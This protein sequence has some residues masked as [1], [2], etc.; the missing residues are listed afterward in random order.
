M[1]NIINALLISLISIGSI[2]N[3][4]A[5]PLNL[6]SAPLTTATTTTVFPNVM[7]VLDNSGSMAWDYLPDIIGSYTS[8][9]SLF[10]NPK[11]NG[12]MY[13]P[14][15]Y[16]E[17]PYYINSD[18]TQNTTTYPIQSGTSSA[19]GRN[20]SN[21][22]NPNWNKVKVDGF[23]VQSSSTVDVQTMAASGKVFKFVPGEICTSINLQ[24]CIAGTTPTASYPYAAS[25]RWCSSKANATAASPAA[26]SCRATYISGSFPY[27]RYPS[28]RTATITI[29]GSSTTVVSSIKVNGV[30]IL[31]APTSS[32]NNTTT[33]AQNIVANINACNGSVVGSCGAAGYGATNSGNVVTIYANTQA[34]LAAPAVTNSSGS[35][36]YA[37][38]AFSYKNNATTSTANSNVPGYNLM[39][40]I[41][42]A[43]TTALYPDVNSATKAGA[44][45]DCSGSMCTA[46]EELINYANWY[47]YYHTR[48]QMMKT[49]ASNAF[50]NIGST[51]RVGF[52]TINNTS[53]NT[54]TGI[55]L[56]VNTFDATQKLAWYNKFFAVS[57]TGSTTLRAAL[58][59]TGRY[60]AHKLGGS[61][62]DPMQYSCQQNFA[63][64]STDGYWNES[65]SSVVKV[66]GSAMTDQ[67]GTG[68]A[69]PK[70]EGSSSSTHSLADA[71]KYYYDTDL[72]SSSLSN[73]TGS[74]GVDVCTDN[75]F[76]NTTDTNSKQH[77]TDFTLGLGADGQLVYQD[78]YL[79]ASTGD[80]Y[81]IKQ[82]TQN[83]PLPASNTST[84]ID[85]LWH[86]AVNANGQYF[87]AKNPTD[88]SNGLINALSQINSR[89]GAG[90][91]AAAS[92]LNPVAGDNYAYVASYTTA[93]WYGNLEQRSIDTTT[94]IISNTVNWCVENVVADT[95]APPSTTVTT[96]TG[97]SSQTSCVT[98]G[99]SAATCVSPGV[100][101][102]TSNTCSVPMVNSCTGTLPPMVSANSDSR[103]IYMAS[104]TGLV[105]FNLSSFNP[106]ALSQYS[107]LST[108]QQANLTIA[109]LVNYLRG[110]KGYE[111]S[112]SNATD[113][114]IFRYRKAVMGD[115]VESAPA[116]IKKPLYTYTDPG[117][118]AFV[119]AQSTR[120]GAVYLGT[121]DGMLHA[122]DA[123]NGVENWAFVPTPVIPSMY[124]LAD[125]NYANLH[126]NYVNGDITI[127]DICT[128]NC[129][130]NSAT[131]KTI[132]VGGL[133]AGGRGYYALDITN[134]TS[135]AFLWEYTVANNANLGYSFGKPRITKKADG[136]WVV[137]V[138]TGYNN[139]DNS[140]GDGIGRLLVLDAATGTQI[141]SISTGVGSAATPSG[142]AQVNGYIS[143][144]VTNNTPVYVYGGDLLGNIWKFDINS[145][146]VAKFASLLDGSSNPQPI[147]VSPNL[148]LLNNVRM[149]YVGTGKYLEVSD[150][151]NTQ[152]QTVYGISDPD[153]TTAL[154]N[155]RTTLVQQIL[156]SVSG[157][158]T[159]TVS[160]NPVPAASRGWYVDLP[161]TGERQNVPAILAL[162]TLIVPT[163]VPTS[164]AC[165]PGGYG[166]VNAFNFETGGAVSNTGTHAD[167]AS[168]QIPSMIVGM[169]LIYTT[170]SQTPVLSVVTSSNSI[171]NP[172]ILIGSG[173][174]SS[175]TGK[176]HVIWRE[177]IY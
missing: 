74:L 30:Q 137:L 149:V 154:I 31:S 99:S 85:D 33:Q 76:T 53:G 62:A 158:G 16:Y 38:T 22:A 10:N 90:S 89:V 15:V 114:Q 28:A 69:R 112:G 110:Q 92:N 152:T 117:Y 46:N 37:T 58:T 7:F 18:G 11:F 172:D 115:A 147:T 12:V 27:A 148:T 146:T 4:Y 13:D 71:A 29:S 41:P 102:A 151:A 105:N 43:G 79:T 175:G 66:D 103:H 136:T 34:T 132:L 162:G 116:Y 91:A 83:W 169:N 61:F 153:A 127:G 77:M 87:S 88:L 108:A 25:L 104:S 95:C 82:G 163:N 54:N 36:T 125:A 67:D 17:P 1:K 126:T 150:L 122:F 32:T 60:Y 86:A 107:S 50:K 97:S 6:A 8:D 109:N 144:L 177:L 24:S 167:L 2:D 170:T 118:S 111:M 161:D 52:N 72:R 165:L 14:A 113:H 49:S 155:P 160:S 130:T 40:V 84:T 35:M 128:A 73:C 56:Q 42:S 145:A 129:T 59:F 135:P 131:W 119:T 23:G 100:F 123:S 9:V 98:A 64:L 124:K 51:Y 141:S 20:T 138:T 3:S 81:D 168:I 101:D 171:V 45:T 75:V 176:K 63:I 26:G 139:S 164:T 140:L 121:N 44:R 47:A 143:S 106:A 173:G 166:W 142:L 19:T 57:P 70:Y 93:D 134:P 157:S 96:A 5:A 39:R 21:A 68:T 156:T 133:H 65:D 120:A 80:Y 174:G 94:G 78:N 55:L 159:R 48:M